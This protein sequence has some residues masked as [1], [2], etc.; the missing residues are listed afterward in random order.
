MCDFLRNFNLNTKINYDVYETK[1]IA[2]GYKPFGKELEI[3]FLDLK[4]FGRTKYDLVLISGTLQ[5]TKNWKQLLKIS[6]RVAKNTL[7]MRL[8]LS[9]ENRN[10]F[11]FNIMK[12]GF[13]VHHMHPSHLLCFQG[14]N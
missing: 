6:S 11:L 2:K 4:Y 12:M 13:T 10:I 7:I 8:P 1:L 5:Y 3:A 14:I 9:P